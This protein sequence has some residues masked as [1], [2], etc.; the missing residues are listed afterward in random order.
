MKMGTGLIVVLGVLLG[1]CCFIQ[2]PLSNKRL[3][4]MCRE[5]IT[6]DR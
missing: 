2:A 1:H 4:Y 3:D 6:L 5:G